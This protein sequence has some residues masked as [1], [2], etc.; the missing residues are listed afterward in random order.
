MT[1]LQERMD[2]ASKLLDGRWSLEEYSNNLDV[3]R[4]ILNTMHA[5][6][7]DK[8]EYVEADLA[9]DQYEAVADAFKKL[10]FKVVIVHE[11]D[12]WDVC[13]TW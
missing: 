4:A 13:V 7:K 3:K 11:C 10:G 1:D 2:K 12:C 5:V 8:T 9:E 6:D